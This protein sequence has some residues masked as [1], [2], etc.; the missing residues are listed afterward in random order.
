[1]NFGEGNRGKEGMA[2]FFLHHD[3]NEICKYLSLAKILRPGGHAKQQGIP[4]SNASVEHMHIA[5]QDDSIELSCDLCGSICLRSEQQFTYL[6][7]NRRQIFCDSC[8]MNVKTLTQETTCLNPVCNAIFQFPY[9]WYANMGMEFPKYCDTC[10]KSRML[11][12]YS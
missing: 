10:R 9:F 7:S 3:C 11:D 5:D 2:E 12:D 4:P 1:M 6:A 8:Q